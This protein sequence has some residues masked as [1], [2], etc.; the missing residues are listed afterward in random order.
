LGVRMRSS[1]E[2]KTVVARAGRYA[3]VHPKSDD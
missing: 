1:N 3:Q 2:A